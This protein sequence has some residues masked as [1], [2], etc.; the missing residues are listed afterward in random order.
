MFPVCSCISHQFCSLLLWIWSIKS[1]LTAHRRSCQ[2]GRCGWSSY[3]SDLSR[4]VGVLTSQTKVQHV[5]LPV[6]GGK[7]AHRKVRLQ[8][9]KRQKQICQKTFEVGAPP[10]NVRE[11]RWLWICSLTTEISQTNVHSLMLCVLFYT[12]VLMSWFILGLV[13]SL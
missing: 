1:L 6:G 8:E 9:H 4:G 11:Y 13:K 2:R 5:A 12:L 7:P 10:V 3:R